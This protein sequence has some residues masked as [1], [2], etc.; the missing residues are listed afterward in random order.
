[1]K[2]NLKIG[3]NTAYLINVQL[4]KLDYVYYE[5]DKGNTCK[6]TLLEEEESSFD[7]ETCQHHDLPFIKGV[8]NRVTNELEEQTT[9]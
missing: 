2:K 1:M 8:F 7:Y 9:H 5:D 3:R 6:R 4:I